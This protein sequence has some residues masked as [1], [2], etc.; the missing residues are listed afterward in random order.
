MI[1]FKIDWRFIPSTSLGGDAFGYHMVDN[2]H[3]AIY[4][5][6]ISGHGVGAALLSVSVINVLRS[7][8]LPKIDFKQPDQVL[9]ALN[10]AFRSESNK[11]MFFTIWY[12][13]YNTL[14]RNL[15][16]ASGGHPPAILI[17][18]NGKN[19]SDFKL[20]RTK[21]YVIGGLADSVYSKDE[22]T[23]KEND[24]LYIFS[25]GVYEIEKKD[26]MMWRFKE[27]Q[28]YISRVS[29]DS[30]SVLDKVYNHAKNIN[31]KDV[32]TDDFTILE[33]EFK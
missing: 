2:D 29:S 31:V 32:F 5:I 28:E 21:N 11:D 24:R 15:I 30:K 9:K 18:S 14:N 25:D 3:L 10:L 4:L 17:S 20:L 6:D 7:H 13:V 33:V 19:E 27:F 1:L 23:I 16:Y 22:Y 26:G 8:S 12:G